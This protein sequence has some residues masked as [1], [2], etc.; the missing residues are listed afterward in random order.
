MGEV[1]V[2]TDGTGLSVSMPDLD[3]ASIP[4]NPTLTPLSTHV[5]VVTVQGTDYDLSFYEGDDGEMWM[6]NRAFVAYRAPDDVVV[7][8]LPPTTDRAARLRA[9]LQQARLMP[10]P[11]PLRALS[12]VR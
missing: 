9:T 10:T 2:S 3:A 5:W 1:V 6:R 8:P 4:Y 12:T 11:D 7:L